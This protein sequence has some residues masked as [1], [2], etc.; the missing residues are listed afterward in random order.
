MAKKLIRTFTFNASAKTVAI[1]GYVTLSNLLLITNTTRNTI[2]YN[3]A[4]PTQTSTISYNPTTNI[5]TIT[6]GYNT[7][8]GMANADKLMIYIDDQTNTTRPE[9]TFTDPVD[10]ARV[11]Q[12]QAL[13]DTD[14]EYGTQISKWENLTM[15]NNRPYAFA[16]PTQ[17]PNVSGM[18]MATSSRIVTITLSTGTAP[19]NGTP[20]VI[21][22]T[23]LFIANGAYIIE[24]GGGTSTFTYSAKALNTT[25]IT[26]IFDANK[27]NVFRG[28]TYTNSQIGGIPTS[29]TSSGNAVTVVTSTAHGLS[30]GNEIA[31]T[32][33]TTTTNPPTGSFVVATTLSPTSF[34]YYVPNAPT[35]TFVT[36]STAIFPRPQ[37]AVLH[38][39]FDGGVQFSSNGTSN[40]EE[41]TRQTRRY[42]RYQSG[43]GIQVSSGTI[44][45]PS[46]QIDSLTSSGTTVTVLTKEQHNIQPG[47]QVLISGANESAYNGTFT[48]NNVTG[49][50]SFTYTA[51]SIPSVSTASGTYYASV[52][53]WY[54]AVNRLGIFDQQNG[55]FF[56]FDGQQI[57]AVQR[58]STYQVSGKVTVTNGSNTV[59]QTNVAFPTL[60]TKQLNIGDYIVLRGQS[61]RIQD[62]DSDTTMTIT[63]S[64]K[65]ASSQ[66]VIVSKTQDT[67]YPQSS[68]NLD[69]MDGNGPSGYTLDLSRMQMFF[70]D[71]SWYGAG[72]IRWGLRGTD[73]RVNY[74]HKT[75]NNNLNYEAYL[76]S[77]NL[78]A[79]YQ[80][81]TLPPYTQLS[82]SLLI[83]DVSMSVSSTNGFPSVGTLSIRSGSLYE[84]VNYSGTGSNT[85][86]NLTRGKSGDVSNTLTTTVSIGSNS[87]VVS[88]ATNLQIGQ[89]VFSTNNAFP[90]GTFITGI[91]GTT[92]TLSQA[93]LLA[94][95]NI[96][97]PPMGTA[98]SASFNYL[99]SDPTIVELA[100]P[101]FAPA[102][103][104]W[105]TSVIMDGNFDDDKSLLFTYGQTVSSSLAINQTK[106]LFSIRVSPSVDNGI[107]AA[108]GA[109]E[110]VNR[111]QLVLRTLGVSANTTSGVMNVLIRANLNGQP[112][113]STAV[114][115]TNAVGNV[116]SAV[117]S[118]LA[119][120]ADYGGLDVQVVG[121][122]TTGGFFVDGTGTLDISLVRDLGNSIL[123]GGGNTSNTGI[124]PDGPD[125]LTFTATNLGLQPVN[126]FGRL[127]WTEAQ[128]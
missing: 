15:T 12:P 1:S 92:L 66:Y 71:Y 105:G 101:T 49:F 122:E 36:S 80:T 9:E 91:A 14:F 112:S 114:T 127:S 87:V 77:G 107:P 44:L 56:E 24:S 76:R 99:L 37:G 34:V 22:D 89:R 17:I 40:Y 55:L 94:N 88:S 64:Y 118:S 72:T 115:W 113:G 117:N 109:R 70:I 4:D 41:T 102:L 95:P 6:L 13:I 52:V 104:H 110:L 83:S 98:S 84:Y 21:Q 111:M 78:P 67:K 38:R 32:G 120:L 60:F 47:T 59:T 85:F 58:K 121:G 73:G 42:F 18:T 57:Y 103:S 25:S 61:Y 79:R 10:K 30:I 116:A 90:D 54:G 46:L 108:F 97:V 69:T 8:V 28:S 51:L 31:V 43:K 124:Y 16:I 23:Y 26:N 82:A 100:Y 128:A 11:S 2:I 86:N 27:T 81:M 5:S 125:V 63:P 53:G 29:M 93:A 75:P 45:K 33:V 68:W 39:P 50:N 123:G 48:I 20:I 96:I 7:A 3:F 62:I 65:G 126:I 119:Q 19:A 106:A 74:V 35:G